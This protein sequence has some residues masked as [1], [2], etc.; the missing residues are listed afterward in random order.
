MPAALFPSQC[1]A[2]GFCSDRG[3]SQHATCPPGTHAPSTGATSCLDCPVGTYCNSS[4][5]VRPE[6][7]PPGHICAKA[8]T[9][10]PMPCA[11]GY[12]CPFEGLFNE[13]PCPTGHFCPD[14]GLIVPVP[15]PPGHYSSQ[16]GQSSPST[17]VV[18]PKG[19]VCLDNCALWCRSNICHQVLF[20]RRKQRLPHNLSFVLLERTLTI[21]VQ[22]VRKVARTAPTRKIARWLAR[23]RPIACPVYGAPRHFGAT[24][25]EIKPQSLR[26]FWFP[27]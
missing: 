27:R 18:C 11:R 17:C 10:V 25:S 7:C 20:A 3:A 12:Y 13:L 21:Y 22:R 6:L 8:Q 24:K 9:I 19:D 1:P 16:I 14:I 2:G 4:G 15:C 5:T 23:P 26:A